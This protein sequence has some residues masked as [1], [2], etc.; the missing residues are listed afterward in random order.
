MRSK[1]NNDFERLVFKN[2]LNQFKMYENNILNL[3]K[4]GFLKIHF[5]NLKSLMNTFSN[6]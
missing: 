1:P 5:P 6:K 4:L 3:V 2:M